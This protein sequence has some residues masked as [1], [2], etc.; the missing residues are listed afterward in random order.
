[1]SFTQ[2]HCFPQ[3]AFFFGG[4]YWNPSPSFLRARQKWMC[5]LQ[6]CCPA[7]PFSFALVFA[8]RPGAIV[9]RQQDT[10]AVQEPW[11]TFGNCAR[12]D[13]LCLKSQTRKCRIKKVS[14]EFFVE[15]YCLPVVRRLLAP[16]GD[17]LT[18]SEAP[19]FPTLS[20]FS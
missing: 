20:P 10:V 5:A 16:F 15:Q 7:A 18:K 1:M 11:S 3:A 6:I 2:F 12:Q 13:L 9:L 8:T 17:S 4:V 19:P 14:R